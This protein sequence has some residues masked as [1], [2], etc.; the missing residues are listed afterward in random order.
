M[1]TVKLADVVI[2]ENRQRRD[3]NEKKMAE[4][5]ESIKRNGLMNPFTVE[6]VDGKPVLRAGERRLRTLR[7]LAEEGFAISLGSQEYPLGE[8]PAV[9]YKELDDLRRLEIEVEEN[10]V[11][12]DFTWAE[13]D[14]ALAALHR[15]RQAQ[16][17]G[18]TV[19]ATAS[20]VLGKPAVGDQITSVS[21]ALL[22]DKHL[23]DPDV[24]KAKSRKEALKI[25]EKKA[26]LE[27]HAI[28]ANAVDLKRSPHTLI[29]GDSFEEVKKLPEGFFDVLVMD[30]PY[31]MGA[32]SFG[33]MAGTG[34]QYKDNKEWYERFLA[35]M[36]DEFTRI[37][38]PSAHLY[39]F[40]D[41]KWWEKLETL[42][43]LA[44]WK[45]FPK[46]LIWDKC[47]KGMLPFPEQGPRRTYETILFAWRGDRKTLKPGAPDV[48]RVPALDKLEHGAQ[49]PVAL[50]N[51]LLSRS[52][53]PGDKVADLYGGT[54]P[55]VVAANQ[56]KLTA[57]YIELDEA[58]YNKALTRVNE[59][60]FD[61][62]SSEQDGIEIEV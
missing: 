53:H 33:S 44:G 26:R 11:R 62:G 16:N 10:V 17:P 51:N 28:L 41:L 61:D 56:L 38:K 22:V 23:D 34:H 37:C 24:A 32:D 18:Q 5:Y 42:M 31:G 60:G 50:Y 2:P 40:F 35:E 55:I 46:P 14:R 43:V 13:R 49:K 20:E 47:G 3:F 59:T 58:N 54:G 29:R 8:S 7:K 52:A 1:I 15:L 57:T 21:E 6:V 12:A 39:M 27:H 25:I 45:V 30:P 9:S 48:I 19:T 4:L 36:P